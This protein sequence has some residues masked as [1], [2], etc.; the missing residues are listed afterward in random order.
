MA[1]SEQPPVDIAITRRILD[2][3]ASSSEM[4]IS[5]LT[6]LYFAVDPDALA[7]LLQESDADVRVDFEYEGR[8]VTIT[9]GHRVTIADDF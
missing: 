4:E 9:D 1:R 2:G 7:S 6:P 8:T 3:V 5:D